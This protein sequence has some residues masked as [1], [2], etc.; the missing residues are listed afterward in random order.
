TLK[1]GK[2]SEFDMVCALAAVY[3]AA[4]LPAR[5][6][7][8][9]DVGQSK[10]DGRRFLGKRGSS[11]LRAWVEFPLVNPRDNALVWVPVDIVRMR[12]SSSRAKPLEQRWPFFGDNDALDRVIPFAFQ[13]HPPTTVVSY[14]SPAF[15]GWLVMPKPPERVLQAVRFS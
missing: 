10:T 5:T 8:G 3:R 6:V 12:K 13:F 4:G 9:F 14:G 1:K 15:W 2:G 11:E 7:I